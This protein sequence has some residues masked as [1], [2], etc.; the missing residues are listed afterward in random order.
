[1]ALHPIVEEFLPI[2]E[3]PKFLL[4]L[5]GFKLRGFQI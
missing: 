3:P 5:G 4:L 1:M 2:N